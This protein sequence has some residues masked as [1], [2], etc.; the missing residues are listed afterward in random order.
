[1]NSSIA[2]NKGLK[3]AHWFSLLELRRL[4]KIEDEANELRLKVAKREE[5]IHQLIS[6]KSYLEYDLSKVIKNFDQLQEKYT[7]NF[8]EL[9]DQNAALCS[10]FQLKDSQQRALEENLTQ[11]SNKLKGQLK[12]INLELWSDE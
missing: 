10:Q 9:S 8:V 3:E 12:E 1:M 6:C 11:V 4:R 5:E 2:K 7:L